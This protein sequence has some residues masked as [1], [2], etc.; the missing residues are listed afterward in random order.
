MGNPHLLTPPELTLGEF[1]A[2]TDEDEVK[3]VFSKY[4]REPGCGFVEIK[5]LPDLMTS[6]GA[7]FDDVE[8]KDA[9]AALDDRS[10]GLVT[11][12][13]FLAYWIS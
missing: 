13:V 2:E 8:T 10:L 12:E 1:H 3:E 4:E 5:V 6:L 7:N 9:L 11:L